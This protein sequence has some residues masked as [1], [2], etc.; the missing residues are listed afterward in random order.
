ME[1][2]DESL[3]IGNE[4]TVVQLAVLDTDAGPRLVIDSPKLGY[5][6]QLSVAELAALSRQEMDL[7]S[8]LLRTPLGPVDEEDEHP[9]FHH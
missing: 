8:D 5:S 7:F 3:Q 9:L 6:C 4:Y 2:T 1:R